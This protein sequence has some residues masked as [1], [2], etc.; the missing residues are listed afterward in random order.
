VGS[1]TLVAVQHVPDPRLHPGVQVGGYCG[2]LT[3]LLGIAGRD[4]AD[5]RIDGQ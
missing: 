5:L 4:S 2:Y 3:D 1:S